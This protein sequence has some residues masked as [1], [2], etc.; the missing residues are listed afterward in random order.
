M[1]IGAVTIG[2]SPRG[3]VAPEFQAAL[4]LEAELLQCG[5][6]DGL[7]LDEVRALAPKP[8]DYILVTRLRDGTE[9]KIAECHIHERMKACVRRLEA[10][11]VDLIV[12]F[13]TGEFP[14]L[15]SG[16]IILKPDVLM[17]HI[18]PGILRKGRLGAVLP[19]PDQI[20][21]LGEKWR[22]TGLDIELEAVS[23]YSGTDED[24]R[25]A[26]RRLAG[27]NV[28]LIVLDCIGF[29]E[30]IKRIFQEESGKPV[31]LPRTLLGRIA[32]EMAGG[33]K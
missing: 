13:C 1:K 15:D 20:P 23:P 30:K 4:G 14:D 22:R 19:S 28:D 12:L 24:F 3:D 26:A 7:S 21:I 18:V 27:R 29:N 11:G 10:A 31:I 25:A 5:A 17:E 2:Q 8:G 33:G 9:V 32:G 16:P 6:L